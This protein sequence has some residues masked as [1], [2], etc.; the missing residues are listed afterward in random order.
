MFLCFLCQLMTKEM[1]NIVNIRD[2]L[3]KVINLDGTEDIKLFAECL[4][5]LS[6]NKIIYNI[7]NLQEEIDRYIFSEDESSIQEIIKDHLKELKNQKIKVVMTG[8][9]Y[10]IKY[11]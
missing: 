7:E 8:G 2:F 1:Y 10:K 11:N 9:R 5:Y 6:S 4:K 3:K